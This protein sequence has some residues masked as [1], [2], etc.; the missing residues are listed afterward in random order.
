MSGWINDIKVL[1]LG[2]A[3]CFLFICLS[4]LP[5]RSRN[6][7]IDA[8]YDNLVIWWCI[9][10]LQYKEAKN[11]RLGITGDDELP[12]DTSNEAEGESLVATVTIE[13]EQKLSD[14]STDQADS[15]K[16]NLL[17]KSKSKKQLKE[18]S[19]WPNNASLL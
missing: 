10:F 2:Y 9:L 19:S 1:W 17:K 16:K 6:I 8:W 5:I 3:I 18:D 15:S 11:R 4:T 12:A 13:N 14:E 7:L